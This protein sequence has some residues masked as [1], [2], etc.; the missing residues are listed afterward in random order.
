M[1]EALAGN[2][3][4]FELWKGHP[5][6]RGE[7]FCW[8][9]VEGRLEKGEQGEVLAGAW[10]GEA[11]WNVLESARGMCGFAGRLLICTRV[12]ASPP[13]VG[14]GPDAGDRHVGKGW[15]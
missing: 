12:C 11:I 6:W 9:E 1:P 14:T 4:R 10:S 7:W 5:S 8:G 2:E 3:V 13:V 15:K